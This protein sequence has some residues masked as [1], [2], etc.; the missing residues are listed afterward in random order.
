MSTDAAIEPRL[1]RGMRDLL[2]D[3]M[4]ARQ[5][6]LDT[7][8]EVYE[9]Y[10]FVPLGT[11]ALEY[12]D[13]LT[14]SAGA[15]ASRSIFRVRNPD[16]TEREQAED[17]AERL[18]LRF[19]LTVPLARVV[20]QYR[21]LPRPFRRYQVASVFRADKPDPGRYREFT[22]FDVDSVGVASE[23]ADTEIIAVACDALSALNVGGYRVRYSSR[24]VLNL[25]LQ[26]ATV[27]DSL[28]LRWPKGTTEKQKSDE[29]ANRTA[30]DVFRVLDK[31]DKLG[32][33]KVRRE[34]TTGYQDDSGDMIP[35]LGLDDS[36]VAR[37]EAFLEIR[38]DRR[39]SVLTQLRR[40]FGDLPD[41]GGE[42]DVLDR[43]STRLGE[44]GYSEDRVQIDL[45]IARGLAYYTG[46]V[47]EANLTDAPHFGSIFGGGR[48]DDLVLRFLGER[49]PATGGSIG[50]D[51]LLAALVELQ[52]LKLRRSTADVLITTLD[53]N[54][55]SDYLAM[56]YEL[57]RAGVKTE[58]Y[59]GKSGYSQSKKQ[60]KYADDSQIPLCVIYGG[61]EKTAG[62]VTVKQMDVGKQQT[63]QAADRA[64]W[65][66]ARPGETQVPRG[67]LLEAVRAR[68]AN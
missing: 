66:Q 49:I 60:F 10:G 4:A 41:A 2:P 17:P 16:R 6:M 61:N 14:G 53:P 29:A 8:R 35:G 50:V 55:T 23:L 39:D 3:Q 20:A 26:Y 47:F 22:Q 36:Q 24:R 34:L 9:S 51:R 64:S 25:L 33:E 45:S 21:E 28:A 37:I 52:R 12:L 40:L 32:I 15:E 43:I 31:L 63:T 19:D 18:G 58:I 57:R 59:L 5:R 30:A 42:I 56:A 27:P 68:L 48:Y 54:M 62:I 46:P 67:E 65:L 38:D 44:L 1:F 7:I 13:V 11:P